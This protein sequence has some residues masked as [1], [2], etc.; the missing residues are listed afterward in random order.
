MVDKK[1]KVKSA[2]DGSEEELGKKCEWWFRRRI[3]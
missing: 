1:I 2:I 3:R